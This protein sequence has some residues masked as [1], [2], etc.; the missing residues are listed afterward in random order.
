MAN[1][2]QEFSAASPVS[3]AMRRRS[4]GAK[5][6]I[7]HG[8]TDEFGYDAVDGQVHM[9]DL[10]ATM[11]HLMGLDHERLMFEHDG[12]PF[13]LTD[14]AGNLVKEIIACPVLYSVR[15]RAKRDPLRESSWTPNR[16]QST[17]TG[18]RF[19]SFYSHYIG[20]SS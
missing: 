14:V 10:H 8:E 4:G 5:G 20:S 19:S 7:T 9:N 17:A 2:P 6:G 15:G 13:R 3:G 1:T 16:R 18:V 12:R 11:L